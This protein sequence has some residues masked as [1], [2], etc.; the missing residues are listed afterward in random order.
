MSYRKKDL[1]QSLK[2]AADAPKCEAADV[3]SLRSKLLRLSKLPSV[4]ALI[5]TLSEA[6]CCSFEVCSHGRLQPQKQVVVASGVKLRTSTPL[7]VSWFP[8][9]ELWRS[10][11]NKQVDAASKCEV[12][13]VDTLGSKFVVASKCVAGDVHLYDSC[14]ADGFYPYPGR[15]CYLLSIE[16]LIKGQVNIPPGTFSFESLSFDRTRNVDV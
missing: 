12:V 4:R 8:S 10:H 6:R 11:L 1:I 5:F 2:Q 3:Q 9:A 16:R 13:E 14:Y 7:E 15:L